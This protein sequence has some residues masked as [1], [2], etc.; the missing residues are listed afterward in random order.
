MIL[1]SE[2]LR[3]AARVETA[4]YPSQLPRGQRHGIKWATASS[5]QLASN[6]QPTSCFWRGSG[7]LGKAGRRSPASIVILLVT[8]CDI[9]GEP[10][11]AFIQR[12]SRQDDCECPASDSDSGQFQQGKH[13]SSGQDATSWCQLCSRA[14]PVRT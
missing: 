8:E 5:Q 11:E 2:G 7:C 14:Q 13:L 9:I 10:G 12:E 4:W 6:M 1:M 3:N